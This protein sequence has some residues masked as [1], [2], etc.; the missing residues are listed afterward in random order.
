MIFKKKLTPEKKYKKDIGILQKENSTLGGPE[1]KYK[2]DMGA[3]E[4]HGKTQW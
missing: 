1:K 3:I 4:G 2:K